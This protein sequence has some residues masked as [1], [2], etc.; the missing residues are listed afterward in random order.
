M[1]ED[2]ENHEK[3]D[4]LSINRSPLRRTRPTEQATGQFQDPFEPLPLLPLSDG[5]GVAQRQRHSSIETHRQHEVSSSQPHSR[6]YPGDEDHSALLRAQHMG[7]QSYE[8][9]R[10]VVGGR[11]TSSERQI[12]MPQYPTH[13]EDSRRQV[14]HQL[15]GNYL[16]PWD[17]RDFTTNRGLDQHVSPQQGFMTEGIH[18]HHARE[19]H[20]VGPYGFFPMHQG[21]NISQLPQHRYESLEEAHDRRDMISAK[22]SYEEYNSALPDETHSKEVAENP[23]M[24]GHSPHREHIQDDRRLFRTGVRVDEIVSNTDGREGFESDFQQEAGSEVSPLLYSHA[25]AHTAHS[26]DDSDA[27]KSSVAMPSRQTEHKETS[28]ASQR[29]MTRDE[30]FAS[31]DSIDTVRNIS[32]PQ[33]KKLKSAD[34][35]ESE[36]EDSRESDGDTTLVHPEDKMFSTSF[37]FAVLSEI[38]SCRFEPSDMKGKRRGLTVGF[39]G[40]S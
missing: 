25:I 23:L 24:T 22:R 26:S 5:S 40:L 10:F 38:Q 29:R 11:N 2:E 36:E 1:S 35:Q 9:A 12:S 28:D 30:Y 33:N 19:H 27:L 18:S 6:H 17:Y 34:S 20:G 31:L 4:N 16:Y 37:S 8:F 7:G 39:P 13:V 14:N 3:D 15:G 32:D 21:R